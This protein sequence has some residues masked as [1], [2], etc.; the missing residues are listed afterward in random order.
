MK[1]LIRWIDAQGNPT[2]DNNPAIGFAVHVFHR[3]EVEP[4]RYIEAG[5]ERF[6]VCAEH[7]K[8]IP[9]LEHWEFEAIQALDNL[10]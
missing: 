1:C 3:V 5:G 8:R 9:M 2:P 7:A 4:D 10:P 6:P